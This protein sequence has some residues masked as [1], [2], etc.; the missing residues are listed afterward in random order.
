MTKNV[1]FKIYSRNSE[2]ML[3][4]SSFDSLV[5]GLSKLY[6]LDSGELFIVSK[7]GSLPLYSKQNGNMIKIDYNL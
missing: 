4:M 3:I 2:G 6:E 7:N 1:L 5:N